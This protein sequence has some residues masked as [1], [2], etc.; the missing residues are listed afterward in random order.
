MKSNQMIMQEARRRLAGNWEVPI[1]SYLVAGVIAGVGGPV[2]LI[3]GGP[4]QYGVSL[5]SLNLSRKKKS[6]FIQIFEGFKEQISE[7]IIAYLLMVLYV[8]LWSILFIIPGII[9]AI[10]YSQ[11]FFILVEDKKVSGVEA[12]ALSKKMMDGYKWKFFCLCSRFIGWFIVSI[13]TFGIGFLW[14]IPY[15]QVSFAN[16]YDDIKKRV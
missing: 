2:G 12:L 1:L 3:I 13:L 7:S 15:V 6:E 14:L 4:M 8:V 10:S 16:F 9:A 5:F 11:T